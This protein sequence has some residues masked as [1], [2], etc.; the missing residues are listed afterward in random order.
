MI[1]K[2][3]NYFYFRN[4]L[5]NNQDIFHLFSSLV[6]DGFVAFDAEYK[7]IAWNHGAEKIFGHV[8]ETVIGQP[9]SVLLSTESADYFYKATDFESQYVSQHEK[10]ELDGITA[11]NKQI[12]IEAS[13]KW[14]ESE[15][16]GKYCAALFRDVSENRKVED[17]LFTE[18][19]FQK[20]VLENL[21]DAVI[22]C[23]AEGK[24]TIINRAKRQSFGQ[25]INSYFLRETLH[26]TPLYRALKGE[27]IK[28]FHSTSSLANGEV[29]HQIINGQAIFD[30]KG[31]KLGAVVV[32]HDV[33]DVVRE[34]EALR[35]ETKRLSEII[36][37]QYDIAV[38]EK[39]TNRVM[40]LI[41]EKM[42]RLAR[43]DGAVIEI[44]DG[45]DSLIYKA[46]SGTLKN[47]LNTIIPV[48]GSLSGLCV[49]S[50]EILI[51]DD[52]EIDERVNREA[53]RNVGARSMIVVPLFSSPGEAIGV[54]KV[55]SEEA[56]FFSD[57]DVETL[58]L[59]SGLLT[60]ALLSISDADAKK[61]LLS[62]LVNAREVAES[63]SQMKSQFLA[64]MSHEIRT[65]M[66]AV[67]GLT[68]LLLDTQLDAEQRD[69][70]NT[71]KNSA[72]SLLALVNDI[73]DISKIEA[74]K[75]TFEKIDFHLQSLIHETVDIISYSAKQK[76]L[77]IVVDLHLDAN[78]SVI[79][80]PIRVRQI[81]LNILSNAIKFTSK[82]RVRLNVFEDGQIENKKFFRF[83][84]I[85][86]G[87]GIPALVK[88]NL[89]ESFSQADSSTTRKFGGTGLGLS[90]CK[91]LV[92]LLKGEIGVESCEGLGSM[93]WFRLPLQ[94]TASQVKNLVQDDS[95]TA[96]KQLAADDELRVLLAEDNAVNQKLVIRM[97][98][99]VG[100]HVDAVDN[101]L[102]ALNAFEQNQYHIILM[103]G[104][105]PDMDG[106]QATVAIRQSDKDKQTRTP[107]IALTA[108]VMSG[109]Y[110]RCL[111]IG[112]DDYIPKPIE[113]NHFY[114]TVKKWLEVAL[115][116]RKYNFPKSA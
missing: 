35:R 111:S 86:T 78:M 67:I 91:R 55:I 28:N 97:L 6:N 4:S 85:D 62:E 29:R 44:S 112:M 45:S 20:A 107:I 11:N 101:G 94:V 87:I 116:E 99:K 105:M 3:K 75:L 71:I 114:K 2:N 9:I 74:G 16:N 36:A 92:D 72:D 54:L 61:K 48:A 56:N 25:R 34:E 26:E 89:F 51:C 104:H 84:V 79:S 76:N 83:E 42:M 43:A 18:R 96:L 110:E 100:L 88:E 41:V 65:P 30:S 109:D 63:A 33:T 60:S 52:S 106:Y 108:N 24:I 98:K 113:Q 50:R 77:E 73:L 93:F 23:D 37:T 7:I 5:L 14:C 53:C 49:L 59:V 27:V 66:N 103:D 21:S 40:Q 38:A 70:L 22:G 15:K 81:L 19:E 64:N 68:G 13:F 58:R 57:I 10:L 12:I 32:T 102:A 95:H 69:F 82:G 8:A 1:E 31:K 47:S 17:E 80:D 39:D 115:A 90:I 46:C